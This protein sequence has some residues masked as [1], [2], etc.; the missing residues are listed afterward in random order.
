MKHIR[1]NAIIILISLITFAC[2]G[3][4]ILVNI[5]NWLV[6]VDPLPSKLDV[7]FSFGGAQERAPYAVELQKK[8]KNALL[9]ISTAVVEKEKQRI[10]QLGAD[11]NRIEFIDSCKTTWTEIAFLESWLKEKYGGKTAAIGLVSSPYHM[12]RIK[13][14][15]ARRKDKNST[16][17]YLPVPREKY[18]QYNYE[19]WW[20]NKDLRTQV[21]A[22]VEKMI[23]FVYLND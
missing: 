1:R 11:T 9:L 4:F 15:I 19:M 23:Y 18:L 10:I 22:E 6:V 7:I 21:I 2:A 17:C 5:G 20:K 14:M 12:R 16:P 3:I 13:M 8:Y